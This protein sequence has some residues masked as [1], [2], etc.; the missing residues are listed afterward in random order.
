MVLGGCFLGCSPKANPNS[1]API[2][3]TVEVLLGKIDRALQEWEG[4][5]QAVRW[6]GGAIW[7]ESLQALAQ[8]ITGD[9]DSE[10]F[11]VW[12]GLDENNNL[13]VTKPFVGKGLPRDLDDEV[14]L[15]RHRLGVFRDGSD[16]TLD[17]F[18][19]GLGWSNESF[20]VLFELLGEEDGQGIAVLLEECAELIWLNS[21]NR[22]DLAF[23]AYFW[24][25][26]AQNNLRR[27]IQLNENALAEI[28][29]YRILRDGRVALQ[30]ISKNWGALVEN[31]QAEQ[32]YFREVTVVVEMLDEFCIQSNLDNPA[33]STI[34][35]AITEGSRDTFLR[36]SILLNVDSLKHVEASI[37]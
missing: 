23:S 34:L 16:S 35:P 21:G 17:S 14:D 19:P 30:E 27:K 31:E 37:P 29:V 32:K 33:W 15:L 36:D 22:H 28:A 4:H 11:P 25:F 20:V 18:H 13:F 6:G 3:S 12:L 24:R 5:R 26:L 8:G 1:A 9:D 10:Y 7:M 2:P